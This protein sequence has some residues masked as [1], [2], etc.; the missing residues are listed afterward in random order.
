MSVCMCVSTP[1]PLCCRK[2][3]SGHQSFLLLHS[4]VPRCTSLYFTFTPRR[5]Y[6]DRQISRV[7]VL[8]TDVEGGVVL[9]AGLESQEE[10]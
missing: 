7:L 1:L 9:Y 2:K 3:Q 8:L 5:N 10:Y 6:A 4:I